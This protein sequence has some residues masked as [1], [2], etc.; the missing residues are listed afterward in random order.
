MSLPQDQTLWSIKWIVTLR[1]PDKLSKKREQPILPARKVAFCIKE[2]WRR[3]VSPYEETSL[4]IVGVLQC[5][6]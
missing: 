2:S 6:S 1:H 3:K 5:W 4:H